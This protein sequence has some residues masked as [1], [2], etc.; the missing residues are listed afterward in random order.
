CTKVA[1]RKHQYW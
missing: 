1:Y